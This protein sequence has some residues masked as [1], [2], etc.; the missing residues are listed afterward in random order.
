MHAHSRIED[1]ITDAC[2][3]HRRAPV[4]VRVCARVRVW[5]WVWR[6]RISTATVQALFVGVERVWFGSQAFGAAPAFNANIG[7]WNVLRVTTY[8]SAFDSVGF[9]DCIKR[10]VY[11]NWG[12][13]LRTAYPTWSSLSAVCAT[14]A[15]STTPSTATPRYACP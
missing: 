7:A 1:R 14:P 10:S 8:A 6:P 9:A 15:P 3:R 4:C 2:V 11:D 12:S 5:V 13:T